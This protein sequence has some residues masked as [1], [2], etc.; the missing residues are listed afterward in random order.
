MIIESLP[1]GVAHCVVSFLPPIE[2]VLF[3]IAI[4]AASRFTDAFDAIDELDFGQINEGLAS[5]L[6]DDDLRD[7]LV[8]SRAVHDLKTLV[9]TNCTGMTGRGLEPIRAST[10]LQFL[11][12]SIVKRETSNM[13]EKQVMICE[14]V[15]APIIDSIIERQENIGLFHIKFPRKWEESKSDTFLTLK[16]SYGQFFIQGLTHC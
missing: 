3:S 7:I 11:D 4:S 13:K 1:S 16:E 10:V 14:E 15:V 9:L 2:K 6:T 5:R 12:L 8:S